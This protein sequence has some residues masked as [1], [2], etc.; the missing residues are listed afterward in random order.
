MRTREN[1][2]CLI[3]DFFLPQNKMEKKISLFQKEKKQKTD[4]VKANIPD[5][6]LLYFPDK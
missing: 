2:P 1:I 6:M 4:K 3:L 5:W